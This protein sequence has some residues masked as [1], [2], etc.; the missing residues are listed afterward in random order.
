[1][2]LNEPGGRVQTRYAGFLA[3][4][5]VSDILQALK[6]RGLSFLGNRSIFWHTQALKRRGP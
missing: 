3:V 2:K 5:K 1:M 4:D 6:R